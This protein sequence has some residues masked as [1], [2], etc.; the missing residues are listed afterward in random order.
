MLPALQ[1]PPEHLLKVP[2]TN[3]R[4]AGFHILL[5]PRI[6]WNVQR[7]IHKAQGKVA[8]TAQ[9][10][11]HPSLLTLVLIRSYFYHVRIFFSF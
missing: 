11:K 3:V 5:L 10:E 4:M 8:W 2:L 7:R 9:A 1:L 6:H